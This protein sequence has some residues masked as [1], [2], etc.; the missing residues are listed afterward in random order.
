MSEQWMKRALKI[1]EKGWG[2]TNPNPLV[3][4]VLVRD[5]QIV[6]EGYHERIG[7]PH[8]EIMAL[9]QAESK[10]EGAD[11]YVTLEPCNHHG[12][13]PPCTEALIN[14]GIRQVF[15]SIKDPNPLVA[16][17]GIEHLRSEGI[18][19]NIGMLE[20]EAA[21]QNEIFIHFIT[22][23]TPFII[24]KA[25][26]S[27]DGKT[28]ANN[29]QSQWI[30]GETARKH[31][32]RIRQRVSG[33]MVGLKTVLQD[34]PHL[35]VRGLTESPIHPLRIVADSRGEIP[36]DCNLVKDK[37]GAKTLVAT[38][39]KMSPHKERQLKDLNVDVLR[40]TSA[41]GRVDLEA[42][43]AELGRRNIDSILLEGGA[44]L[45]AAA[46]EDN[47]VQK[48][49]FYVAPKLIGGGYAPGVLLGHGIYHMDD[50]I[51]VDNMTADLI[52]ED[53]LI[54]GKIQKR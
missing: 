15:V 3:G 35:T 40:T 45:A 26:M 50:C 12:K 25:A 18:P 53:L 38:T 33:I 9:R 19:V 21:E 34:D 39:E 1:A 4:A 24:Y 20:K 29:G 23:R 36:L 14:A 37:S 43:M 10:A 13:T 8:A 16:G 7:G 44:T 28:A 27:L 5:G 2:A 22:N 6:G 48:I 52:G 47:L 51:K 30:T 11:L 49:M 54:T 32:H 41:N 46:I 42:L 31:V 17:S